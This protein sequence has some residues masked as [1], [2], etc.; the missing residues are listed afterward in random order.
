MT[1]YG[2]VGSHNL[3]PD[4]Q[5]VSTYIS[6][7]YKYKIFTIT[8]AIVLAVICTHPGIKALSFKAL[9]LH[10]ELKHVY[11]KEAVERGYG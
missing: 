7:L 2:A 6:A 5:K 1:N 9:F 11:L 8:L 4:R 3:L 10:I